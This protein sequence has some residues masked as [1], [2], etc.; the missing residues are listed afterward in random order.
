MTHYIGNSPQTVLDG[1]RSK[2]LYGLRRNDDGELFLVRVDQLDAG[3]ANSIII[4]EQ[5]TSTENFPDF[6]EGISYLDGIDETHDVVYPNLRYP[7]LNWNSRLLT[8]YVEPNTG[9]FVQRVSEDY[10]YPEGI[11]T[12]GYN[13]GTDFQVLANS[14]FTDAAR[15]YND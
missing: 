11:S 12:P 3:S 1:I 4:N 15:E 2:Y 5:G 13:E 6:E 8:Y 7:Q 10:S 14:D 9:Q